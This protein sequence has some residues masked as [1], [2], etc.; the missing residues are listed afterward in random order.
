MDI[1]KSFKQ[2]RN[3]Q[4]ID[5][6]VLPDD[7]SDLANNLLT[8]VDTF[9]KMDKEFVLY[10]E[11]ADEESYFENVNCDSCVFFQE[12]GTCNLVDGPI[13]PDAVCRFFI[14]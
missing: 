11:P 1:K 10:T 3:E 9:G 5:D 8:S 7:L 12:N 4:Q 14:V 6:D 13:S 2:L